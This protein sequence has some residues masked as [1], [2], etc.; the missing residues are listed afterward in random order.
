[1]SITPKN[2]P[3]LREENAEFYALLIAFDFF[4]HNFINWQT[5]E[6]LSQ[7][8]QMNEAEQQ[9]AL[10]ILDAL[11]QHRRRIGRLLP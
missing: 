8:K 4:N 7:K 3:P 2:V 1:M 5:A 9:Q 11:C 10:E 6:Q